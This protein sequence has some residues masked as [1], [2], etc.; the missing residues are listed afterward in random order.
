M[1]HDRVARGLHSM[2]TS[3]V[4]RQRSRM[5]G[6]WLLV[7]AMVMVAAIPFLPKPVTAQEIPQQAIFA[8]VRI[9][10]WLTVEPDD[11]AVEPF[12]CQGYGSVG[13]GTI[14]DGR[15]YVLTNHHVISDDVS[16]AWVEECL[17]QI[18]GG[19]SGTVR[20]AFQVYVPNA[21]GV[22]TTA[23][24]MEVIADSGS[25]VDDLAVLRL[26][27]RVDG[28]D[29]DTG[30]PHVEFGDSD[31]LR[32]GAQVIVLGYPANA[33]TNLSI[34]MGIFSGLT[35]SRQFAQPRLKTDA[36]ISGGNSGGTA[37]TPEGLF[38]GIP[39][40]AFFGDCRQTDTN[41]D[42][43]VDDQDGCVV[44]G[45]SQGVLIPSNFARAFAEQALGETIP[46]QPLDGG[47]AGDD[48][49]A[50]PTL[51]PDDPDGRPSYG[52]GGEDDP[53]DEN[54]APD[55]TFTFTAY[56]AAGNVLTT[57]ANVYR[58]MGC[59]DNSEIEGG[60]TVSSSWIFE[61]EIL[62]APEEF[63]WED[64]WGSQVCMA[65]TADPNDETM[66]L[67]TGAYQLVI[68]YGGN[69]YTSSDYEVVAATGG[70]PDEGAGS[71]SE[72]EDGSYLNGR[73]DLVEATGAWLVN[74][75]EGD[76]PYGDPESET[77]YWRSN[78][79]S[80]P[81]DSDL[82]TVV[83]FCNQVDLGT[84]PLLF[85]VVLWADGEGY[86][87]L[88]TP[89]GSLTISHGDANGFTTLASGQGGALNA[90]AGECNRLYVVAEGGALHVWANGAYLGSAN[91]LGAAAW[92]VNLMVWQ[93]EGSPPLDNPTAPV[94]AFQGFWLGTFTAP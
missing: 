55:G 8:A 26:T 17:S 88:V 32:L 84:T 63:T 70:T 61:G 16:D 68:T 25:M 54:R 22:P 39:S 79:G 33:G 13:S 66:V 49:T 6:S 78:A 45:G 40:N 9:E 89:D 60:E 12:A 27:E 71:G 86:Y 36:T 30:F 38:I 28:D 3:S 37:I 1:H 67:Q 65:I 77:P 31:M 29:M 87:A 34:T 73:I 44:V 18:R 90:A 4:S 41:H 74:G 91:G 62:I 93:R 58:L 47:A 76:I 59:I 53:G 64:G 43:E 7:A 11:D 82:V 23:Y 85:G 48:P 50:E 46:V 72:F 14:F 42:L 35:D 81:A 75:T 69:T 15:G 21:Q 52:E 94:M 56:D 10:S 83:D 92:D 2:S 51:E 24:R 20:P 19:G 5:A 80:V 57:P